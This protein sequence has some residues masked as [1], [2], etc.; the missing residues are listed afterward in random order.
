LN[1][2]HLTPTNCQLPIAVF[3][4]IPLIEKTRTL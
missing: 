1:I 3:L 2:Y 4:V